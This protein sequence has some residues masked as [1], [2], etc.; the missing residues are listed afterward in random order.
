MFLLQFGPPKLKLES[1]NVSHLSFRSWCSACVRGRGLSQ[2]HRKADTKTEEAEQVPTVSV[3]FGF[4]GLPEDR[5]H[6]TL[7]VLI[8]GDCKSRG[9]WSHPVPSKGVTHLYPARALVADPD[10]MGVQE[11]HPQVR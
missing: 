3:D 9:I 8:V 6:D 2:G 1:H 5:A 10:F 7:P 11:S 4:F